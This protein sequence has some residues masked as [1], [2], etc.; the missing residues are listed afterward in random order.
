[1]V[2]LPRLGLSTLRSL[3][4]FMLTRLFQSSFADGDS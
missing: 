4:L 1:M 2:E 3:A